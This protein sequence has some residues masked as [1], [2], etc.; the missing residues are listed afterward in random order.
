MHFHN[1]ITLI[2]F[3][4]YPNNNYIFFNY[5]YL[6]NIYDSYYIPSFSIKL[7]TILI[8]ILNLNIILIIISF[9]SFIINIHLPLLN[10]NH[11]ILFH[12]HLLL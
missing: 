5:S 9:I 8:F 12:Y 2:Y 11:L 10:I 1:Q 3:T 4:S 6:I 7:F